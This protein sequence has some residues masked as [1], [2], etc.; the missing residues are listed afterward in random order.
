[1]TQQ[2][3]LPL[4]GHATHSKKPLRQSLLQPSPPCMLSQGCLLHMATHN[5]QHNLLPA[6]IAYSIQSF[7]L[8]IY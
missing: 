2:P 8:H 5:L 1:M 7:H 3:G 4:D 6:S